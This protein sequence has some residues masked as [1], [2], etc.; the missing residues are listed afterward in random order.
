MNIQTFRRFSGC[1][2]VISL[3]ALLLGSQTSWAS[4][5][6]TGNFGISC[7][8]FKPGPNSPT[9]ITVGLSS[10]VINTNNYALIGFKT[11]NA[12]EFDITNLKYSTD[13]T[14]FFQVTPTPAL[15]G[16]VVSSP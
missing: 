2:R 12:I 4:C 9:E 16:I 6:V 5:L 8:E 14:N 13:G 15:S 1:V 3:L 7:T 10:S 11:T